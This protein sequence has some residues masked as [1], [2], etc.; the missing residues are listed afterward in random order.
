MAA[1]SQRSFVRSR[2]GDRPLRI[3][4]SGTKAAATM[5]GLRARRAEPGRHALPLR[6][7]S[8]KGRVKNAAS[9]MPCDCLADQGLRF[10]ARCKPYRSEAGIAQP[11]GGAGEKMALR[12]NLWKR[13][14]A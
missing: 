3:P 6:A 14:R 7:C 12:P 4:R 9:R 10:D 13:G 5:K 2:A 8:K 1:R 11:L